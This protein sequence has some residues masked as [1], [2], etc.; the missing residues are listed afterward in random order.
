M[1][2]PAF[3]LDRDGTINV[4]HDFVHQ[5]SEWEWIPGVPETLYKLQRSGFKL[6]VVTNQS[7]VAR[8]HFSLQH[9][10]ELH[11][12]ADRLLQAY[13]VRIDG[14]YVAPWHP[15]F[16][17]GKDP[18]LL[19]ERKPG[20]ALFERAAREHDID[21]SRSFMAGDKASDLKPAMELGM[22]PVMLTSRFMNDELRQWCREKDISIYENLPRAVQQLF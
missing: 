17:E 12:Y 3:F 1:S 2:A 6:I 7:G 10:H 21:L 18:A 4:D 15:A 20:T 16:H 5:P 8:R 14:W 22:R 11:A 9:V 19:A 13:D